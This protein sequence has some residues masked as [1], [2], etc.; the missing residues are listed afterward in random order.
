MC[1]C[2]PASSDSVCKASLD[3]GGHE[4]LFL[5]WAR[6]AAQDRRLLLERL[7]ASGVCL[8]QTPLPVFVKVTDAVSL[9][10]LRRI[11]SANAT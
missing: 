6:G 5:S 4:G 8:S 9:A 1:V 10:S 7:G 2:F 3:V 11:K